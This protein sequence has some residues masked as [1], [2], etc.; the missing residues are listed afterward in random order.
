MGLEVG[1]CLKSKG[2]IQNSVCEVLSKIRSLNS[3][4]S[5]Q[6][7]YSVEVTFDEIYMKRVMDLLSN[8]KDLNNNSAK[9]T[10]TAIDSTDSAL[11]LLEAGIKCRATA[12]TGC[13]EN[14]SRSHAIFSIYV[15]KNLKVRCSLTN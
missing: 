13:N 4:Q 11:K 3:D 9:S 7:F 10:P 15:L 2:V 14:S 12:T 5:S 8:N 1:S 6:F